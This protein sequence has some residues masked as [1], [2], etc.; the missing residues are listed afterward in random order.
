MK[1]I[2][3]PTDFSACANAATEMALQIAKLNNAEI[4]FL[5]LAVDYSTP[6]HVPGK[7]VIQDVAQIGIIRDNLDQ[8]VKAAEADGIKAKK[9]LV[10]GSGQEQ[11][12]DYILPYK[13]DLLVM[14]SHGATGIRE[15][16]VGSNTQNVIKDIRIP[17]LVVKQMPK[18]KELKHIVF[19][20][21]FKRDCSN[22]LSEVVTFS[23]LWSSRV[24][25]L[26]INLLNHLIEENTARSMMSDQMK[27]FLNVDYTLNIT[28]TNDK[29]FGI[30]QFASEIDADLIAIAM[31]RKNLIG[32]LFTS[33]I[34]ER[35]I[36]HSALPILVVNQ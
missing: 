21:N 5:H 19:A 31:E 33:N 1:R 6:A 30:A 13:I 10:I 18:R 11:I 27:D 29:E 34:A 9:E 23:R 36:N 32:R 28:E 4:Y 7:S 20:S 16:V 26:F 25:L 3:V 17:S 14:G 24:H 15:M 35:L 8:L 2:L 22:S 12:K